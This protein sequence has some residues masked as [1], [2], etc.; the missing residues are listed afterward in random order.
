MNPFLAPMAQRDGI[1]N[2]NAHLV[3]ATAIKRPG[4]MTVVSELISTSA[5]VNKVFRLRETVL[6]E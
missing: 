5:P 4:D 6:D 2:M 3:Q 1:R